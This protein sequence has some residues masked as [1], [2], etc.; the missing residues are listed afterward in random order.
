[1]NSLDDLG[2]FDDMFHSGGSDRVPGKC[3]QCTQDSSDVEDG[4]CRACSPATHQSAVLSDS[5][6]PTAGD[7]Q[8]MGVRL[9]AA[10]GSPVV[11]TVTT[12]T[13]RAVPL[14]TVE[15]V[16]SPGIP[17]V[18]ASPAFGTP[19]NRI[20]S[21]GVEAKKPKKALTEAQAAQK[22]LTDKNH[23]QRRNGKMKALLDAN[24]AYIARIKTLEKTVHGLTA[25]LQKYVGGT[26][27]VNATTRGG[28]HE[29]LLV[30]NYPSWQSVKF[31]LDQA[32]CAAT[33]TVAVRSHFQ[34]EA[35]DVRVVGRFMWN[36][37]GSEL[38]GGLQ[39]LEAYAN[40]LLEAGSGRLLFR[41]EGKYGRGMQI[42]DSGD[43]ESTEA[44]ALVTANG[45]TSTE[46]GITT[47]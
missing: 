30:T 24:V 37:I 10:A 42:L 3:L 46:I 18:A 23:Q 5:A 12:P 27:N 34:D 8:D 19:P 17:V 4:L 1:M 2:L 31:A 11:P 28:L 22:K 20:A 21:A 32:Y 14:Q 33:S 47:A 25:S 29:R 41:S 15:G 38:F 16:L 45:P 9:A 6:Q 26:H 7:V 44:V 13:P 35:D 36:P 39:P 40:H 43:C